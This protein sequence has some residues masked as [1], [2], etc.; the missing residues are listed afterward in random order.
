M[1]KE[2]VYVLLALKFQVPGGVLSIRGAKF[3]A[4]APVCGARRCGRVVR[5]GTN[6]EGFFSAWCT[7]GA[8]L[9]GWARLRSVRLGFPV[10][11]GDVRGYPTPFARGL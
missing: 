6:F 7:S 5:F 3:W 8:G 1:V 2:F 4:T 9:S 11:A 10:P